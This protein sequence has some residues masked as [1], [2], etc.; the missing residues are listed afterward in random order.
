MGFSK[1]VV[2]TLLATSTLVASI[3]PNEDCSFKYSSYEGSQKKYNVILKDKTAANSHFEWL[4]N[5]LNKSVN[6]ILNVDYSKNFEENDVH[7][8]SV[9]DA[10]YGYSTYFDPN[11]V[12]QYL[13]QNNDVELAEED[14]KVSINFRTTFRK[15]ANPNLDRIDQK[16]FPLDTKY[17]FPLTA[18]NGVTVYIVDT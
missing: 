14:G 1:F 7:D 18:G 16:N 2:I 3:E 15:K 12:N 9:E 6:H 10:L 13:K 5:C 8:F 17:I 4:K 11:F